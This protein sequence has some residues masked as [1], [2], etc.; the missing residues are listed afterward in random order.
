MRLAASILAGLLAF[1]AFAG[2]AANIRVIGF[3]SDGAT[4]A[5]EQFGIQD[6]SGFP[7]AERVY[8]NAKTDA[9]LPGT[10]VRVSL[11]DESR[12]IAEARADARVKAEA[13]TGIADTAFE[14]GQSE[15]LAFNPLTESGPD[16]LRL[17]F[18]DSVFAATREPP[19]TVELAITKEPAGENCYGFATEQARF[20]LSLSDMAT[21]D[22]AP[23]VLHEDAAVPASRKCPTGY[24][25]GGVVR[26]AG[27]DGAKLA[28]L[29]IVESIG[30]EGP[31]H[32]WIAV[33]KEDPKQ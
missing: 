12:T 6:G 7:Y 19:R 1:P 2:D 13:A 10:P 28:V 14:G 4:F 11:E 15:L 23:V 18:H 5:F 29:V 25:I 3:S 8:I 24:S 30:F 17:A 20:T 26:T 31:D 32:R 9:F 27:P 22:A 16:K 33:V 21:P